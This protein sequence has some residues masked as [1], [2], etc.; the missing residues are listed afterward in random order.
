MVFKKRYIGIKINSRGILKEVMEKLGVPEEKFAATC[1]LVDKLE[2][3]FSKRLK[4]LSTF[5]RHFSSRAESDVGDAWTC[6]TRR[7]EK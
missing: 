7:L 6:S 3:V 4:T 1:V 2:K 5:R